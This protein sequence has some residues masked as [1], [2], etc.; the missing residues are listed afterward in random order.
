MPTTSLSSFFVPYPTLPYPPP[1]P[2]LLEVI[3]DPASDCL[4]LVMGYVEGCTL[5]PQQLA[6]GR[7]EPLPEQSVWRHA[8]D[9][10][11]GL[12]YLHAHGVVHGDLKPAN[13]IQVRPVLMHPLHTARSDDSFLRVVS[14][15]WNPVQRAWPVLGC[16][17][18]RRVCGH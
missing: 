12:E 2:Q 5:Q 8:R 6:P 16:S 18:A 4:L 3:D 7:W 11:C 1:W 17:L 15:A 13:F 9:V 14:L 10:I